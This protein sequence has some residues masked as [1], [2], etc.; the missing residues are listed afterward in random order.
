MCVTLANNHS[1]D[2]GY[3]AL[4]D[5]LDHLSRAEISAL[6]AGVDVEQARAP[7]LLEAGG[8]RVAVLGFTDHP[9]GFAAG[10]D[11]PGVAYADLGTGI[12]HWLGYQVQVLGRQQRRGACHA[13]LG[14]GPDHQP[15]SLHPVGGPRRAR[16]WG[17]LGGWAFH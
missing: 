12:P 1:L 9:A 4:S 16:R 6:G 3:T 13:A 15:A 11:Q 5:T 14:A 17:D 8:L 2:F 10:P 7:V